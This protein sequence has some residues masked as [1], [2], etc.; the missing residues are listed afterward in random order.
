MKQ[1]FILLMF[2]PMVGSAQDCPV[3][4]EKDQFSQEPKVTTGF[5]S[6]KTTKRFQLS[7][8]GTKKEIDFFFTF[9]NADGQCFDDQ[10]NVVVTFEGGKLKSTFKNTGSM[11][12]EGLF[13]FTHKNQT[14]T[15]SI[16]QR[17]ATKKI[18]SM[19]FVG[20]NKTE[21]EIAL[22]DQQQE[23]MMQLVN[24]VVNESKTLL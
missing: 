19:K 5:V 14:V 21:F 4:K 24:C 1:L 10:S 13:H 7:L 6:F 23:Q 2:L 22:N 12:C 18:V 17:L 8:D 3:K 9:P 15:P 11:N 16:L 20:A